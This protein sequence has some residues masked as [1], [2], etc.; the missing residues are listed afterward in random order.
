MILIGGTLNDVARLLGVVNEKVSEWIRERPIFAQAVTRA[1]ANADEQVEQALNH[2]ARGYSHKSE[3]IFMTKDGTIV[4]APTIKHYPPDTNA[5]AIWLRNR[6]P[7]QWN[8]TDVVSDLSPDEA[9]RRLRES[10]SKVDDSV[11]DPKK[12]KK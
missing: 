9:K 5:N 10:M 12:V 7:K 2:R 4:R 3:E 6:R 1:R 11:P 8:K